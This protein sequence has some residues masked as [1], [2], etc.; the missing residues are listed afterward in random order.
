MKQFLR[1]TFAIMAVILCLLGTQYI[2]NAAEVNLFYD[3]TN[4]Y[5]TWTPLY[6]NAGFNQETEENGN[7]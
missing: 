2:S 1:S 6:G 4:T 7:R 5:T 3:F